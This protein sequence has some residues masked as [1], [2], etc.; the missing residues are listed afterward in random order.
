VFLVSELVSKCAQ[1]P[2]RVNAKKG[3]THRQPDAGLEGK[4]LYFPLRRLEIQF[5]N[6]G[7][8]RGLGAAPQHPKRDA[9]GLAPEVRSTFAC[10]GCRG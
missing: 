3:A 7:D 4:S 9:S 1:I 2:Y 6:A 10:A 5:G 8:D